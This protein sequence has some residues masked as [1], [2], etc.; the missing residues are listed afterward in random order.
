MPLI[1]AEEYNGRIK[2]LQQHL[3]DLDLDL[4]IVSAEESILYLTGVSYTPLER[5]FFILV[6][7]REEPELLVPKLERDHLAT[8]HHRHAVRDRQDLAQLV[9]DQDHR[10]ALVAQGGE[11]TEQAVGL[12]RGEDPRR[13]V[14]DQ[15]PGA[16]V[17]RLEDLDPLAQADRKP[18]DHCLDVDLQAVV[19]L[20]ALQLLPGRRRR[21]AQRRCRGDKQSSRSWLASRQGRRSAVQY[22][23][24]PGDRSTLARRLPLQMR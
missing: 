18:A 12:L 6:R 20:E 5:P 19:P 7:P 10:D 2:R 11:D 14:E 15:D 4:F 1:T 23:L 3:V 17:E 8:A 21:P 16:A 24:F 13:L 9:G 22:L